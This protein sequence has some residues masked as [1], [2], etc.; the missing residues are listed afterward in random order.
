M[1]KIT[2]HDKDFVPYLKHD[3]IQRIVKDLAERVYEDYKD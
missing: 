1:E 3:E 2:I